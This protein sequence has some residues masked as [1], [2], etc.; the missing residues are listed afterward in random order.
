[1]TITNAGDIDGSVDLADV[2]VDNS[3]G[4]DTEAET[5]TTPPG[6]LGAL[7][8]ITVCWDTGNDGACTA[9]V[10]IY[11]GSLDGFVSVLYDQDELLEAAEIEFITIE[12]EWTDDG[13]GLTDNDAQGDVAT[14][15]FT[16]ELDQTDD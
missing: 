14:L 3:E 16:V 10:T 8:T 11:T 1:M 7:L 12:W 9:D 2:T 5:D 6:D 13:D 15:A 4:T